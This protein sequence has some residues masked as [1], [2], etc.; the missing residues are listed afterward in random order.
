MDVYI[1][2]DRRMLVV[3]NNAVEKI[4]EVYTTAKRWIIVAHTTLRWTNEF[5]WSTYTNVDRWMQ[6]VYTKADGCMLEATPRQMNG[7]DG[8]WS[9]TQRWTNGYW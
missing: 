8:Y 3:Y 1:K 6:G 5:W 9:C 7:L 4:L 2:V